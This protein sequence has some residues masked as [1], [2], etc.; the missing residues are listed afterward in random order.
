MR[1]LIAIVVGASLFTAEALAKSPRT[2]PA[3]QTEAYKSAV[4]ESTDRALAKYPDYDKKGTPLYDAVQDEI[5]RQKK[6]NP[7]FFD[8]TD[9]PERI[10]S[11]CATVLGIKAVNVK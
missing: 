5:Q 6:T 1:T 7:A 8:N 2:A 10:A 9:W 3:K 4:K 11:A